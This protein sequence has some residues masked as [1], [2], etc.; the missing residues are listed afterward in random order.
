MGLKIYHCKALSDA[1]QSNL[2]IIQTTVLVLRNTAFKFWAV[3]QFQPEKASSKIFDG[4]FLMFFSSLHRENPISA[5]AKWSYGRISQGLQSF[6]AAC[7]S[8]VV[9][10]DI[11]LY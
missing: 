6:I 5:S 7:V 4:I 8:T 9:S 3:A 11:I 1:I 10:Y 2:K